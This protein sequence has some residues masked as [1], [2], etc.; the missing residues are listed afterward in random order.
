MPN[1]HFN[2]TRMGKIP[3]QAM[4]ERYRRTPELGP[5][6][7]FFSGGTALHAL[8]QML[9]AYTYNSIH[10]VTPFDDGG[11]SRRLRDAFHMIAIG[12]L[13][14]RLMALSGQAVKGSP[15]IYSLFDHR[16]P[17][18]GDNHLLAQHLKDIAKGRDPLVT[19]IPHP[20]RTILCSHLDY[21]LR[22]MP[23]HFDLQ[24][25][26]I[27]NLI[28]AGVYLDS[29]TS[30]DKALDV[31]SHLLGVRGVVRPLLEDHLHLAAEL[32]NGTLLAGQHLITGKE[33][34]QISCPIKRIFLSK[35]LYDP[36]PIA[37]QISM[38]T[39]R[40]ICQA[41]LI[42]YPMG[43]FYTSVVANLIP[44]GVGEA[45]ADNPCTKVYI[46]NTFPD[47]EQTGMDLAQAVEII[48]SSLKKDKPGIANDQL[49]NY[50]VL[51][52]Q[53][54][55]YPAPVDRGRIH[56]LGVDVIDTKLVTRDTAPHIDARC[57]IDV[58]LSLV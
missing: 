9:I 3:D 18:Q 57:L 22:R 26:N 5:R 17:K 21:F 53:N 6:I 42:C 47:P 46:P 24:G 25:A 50:I 49:L 14:K 33:V 2:H 32:E 51:D 12:D 23:A 45:V 1:K 15:Q 7:L 10:L 58:L 56:E 4:I 54:V 35:T 16:F 41:D 44:S 48:L 28:L 36:T 11:S 27:G 30:I 55:H 39:R 29:D 40:L 38:D 20:M 43:S 19:V 8:S 52:T 37:A 34:P 13:R 31:L